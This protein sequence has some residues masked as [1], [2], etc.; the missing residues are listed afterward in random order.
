MAAPEL[1][2]TLV[3]DEEVCPICLV[4]IDK[5][6]V[7]HLP[8]AHKFHLECLETYADTKGEHWADMK[9]VKCK[10]I[11]SDVVSADHQDGQSDVV[12]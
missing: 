8:C 6:D 5:E 1:A 7:Q 10:T 12:S 11:P 2:D 4:A 3:Q 9:C